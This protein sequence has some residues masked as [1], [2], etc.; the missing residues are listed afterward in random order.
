[1]TLQLRTDEWHTAG[2]WRAILLGATP[3]PRRDAPEHWAPDFLEWV[4]HNRPAEVGD[5]W[6]VRQK[7]SGP[8][9]I[10]AS[11]PLRPETATWP[12]SH[13][14]LV[15]PVTSCRDGVHPWAHAY[16]CPA[17]DT[18]GADCKIGAGRLSCWDWTGTVGDHNLTANPSLMILPTK[19]A[20]GVAYPASDPRQ[21]CR[22][23]GFLRNGVLA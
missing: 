10:Y 13:Y 8:H 5:V 16:N 22:F 1:M 15:C 17:G 19:D 12:V 2:A 4:K 7:P 23:H 3:D 18:N 20:A 21:T 6:E 11:G 9:I 14:A